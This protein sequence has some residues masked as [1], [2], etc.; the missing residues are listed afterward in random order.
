[1]SQEG[2]S[3]FWDVMVSAILSIK[4]YMY[5]YPIPNSFQDRARDVIT[6]IKECQDALRQATH[7]LT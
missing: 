3:I 4:V 6:C 2:R 5:M 1:M 7:V